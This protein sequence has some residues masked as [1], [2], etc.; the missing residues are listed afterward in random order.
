[1]YEKQ[2]EQFGCKWTQ[3]EFVL[4][5]LRSAGPSNIFAVAILTWEKCVRAQL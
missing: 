1:L 5:I 3:F 2:I 4:C